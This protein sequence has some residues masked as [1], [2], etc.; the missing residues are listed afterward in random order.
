MNLLEQI[1]ER[2]YG[3][4]VGDINTYKREAL[5]ETDVTHNLSYILDANLHITHRKYSYTSGR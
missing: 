2:C 4:I 1:L 5:T 3:E